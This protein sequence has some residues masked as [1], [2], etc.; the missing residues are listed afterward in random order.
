MTLTV[1]GCLPEKEVNYIKTD[2][3]KASKTGGK[4]ASCFQKKLSYPMETSIKLHRRSH[5]HLGLVTK[6]TQRKHH[7]NTAIFKA[8]ATYS[9]YTGTSILLV[10]AR[11]PKQ[12]LTSWH[13]GQGNNTH[14]EHKENRNDT[15]SCRLSS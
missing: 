11:W 6:P 10:M 7:T 13:G 5:N 15:Y 4:L 9:S 2:T 14:C 3:V 12:T 8:Y 1:V